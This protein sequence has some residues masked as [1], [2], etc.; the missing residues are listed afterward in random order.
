MS[1]RVSFREMEA[2]ADVFRAQ[3]NASWRHAKRPI[4]QAHPGVKIPHTLRIPASA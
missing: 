3:G 4:S 1:L 2:I